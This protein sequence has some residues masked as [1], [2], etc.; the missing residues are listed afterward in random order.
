VLLRRLSDDAEEVV[1]KVLDMKQLAQMVDPHSLFLQLNKILAESKKKNLKEK[2]LTLLTTDILPQHPN[3][4]DEIVTTLLSL[5]L[6]HPKVTY[7]H[8]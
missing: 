2:A 7:L 3:Y 4:K 5:V 1:S 8:I 6:I